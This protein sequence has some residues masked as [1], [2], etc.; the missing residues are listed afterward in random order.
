MNVSRIF[1]FTVL[2][3]LSGLAVSQGKV[4]GTAHTKGKNSPI[5]S[6]V[7]GD[8]TIT[9][10]GVAITPHAGKSLSA[11]Q[12]RKEL[13]GTHRDRKVSGDIS[14][15]THGDSSPVIVGGSIGGKIIINGKEVPKS[16]H[17]NVPL[18]GKLHIETNAPESPIIAVPETH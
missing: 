7:V 4:T 6:G 8:V 13:S 15:R 18:G 9:D 10:G 11:E 3:I 12:M 2:C 1:V 16:T 5:I 17:I 14:I